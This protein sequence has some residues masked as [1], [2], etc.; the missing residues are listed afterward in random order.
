MGYFLTT[1]L[2]LPTALSLA[3]PKTHVPLSRLQERGQRFYSPQLGRWC[4]RDPLLDEVRLHAF[5]STQ[6]AFKSL[7]LFKELRLLPVFRFLQNSPLDLVD[8]LGLLEIPGRWRERCCVWWAVRGIGVGTVWLIHDVAA[9]TAG[10]EGDRMA[11]RWP[12]NNRE[13]MINALRHCLAGCMLTASFG[14]NRARNI[15]E[16]HEA[17]GVFGSDT[18]TDRNNNA[19][20]NSLGNSTPRPSPDDCLNRCLSAMGDGSLDLN[21]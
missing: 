2:E 19:A 12:T 9:E 10:A 17:S 13:R 6:P 20:G 8:P 14:P 11:E 18:G 7:K 1:S 21:P 5:L 4:S 16:C 3:S 15:E